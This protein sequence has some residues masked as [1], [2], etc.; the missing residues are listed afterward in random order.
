MRPTDLPVA[1]KNSG[2]A[3]ED[4]VPV[5]LRSPP[6]RKAYLRVSQLL[7]RLAVGTLLLSADPRPFFEYLFKSGRAFADF[8][9]RAPRAEIIGSAFSPV[10]D[11]MVCRDEPGV[12][13]LA[14][15]LPTAPNPSKEYEEDFFYLSIL[16][17]L[18]LERKTSARTQQWLNEYEKLVAESKQEDYRLGVCRALMSGA[19]DKIDE[20]LLSAAEH[21]QQEARRRHDEERFEMDEGNLVTRVSIDVLAWIEVADRLGFAIR[22]ALPMAPEIARPSGSMP[23]PA[24][25]SWRTP[26]SFR[27]L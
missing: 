5:V 16:V 10:L 20:T 23:L 24:P 8:C 1:V 9:A 12:R 22:G 18:Y 13:T 11:A 17:A 25:D 15:H 4:L 26:E 2:I 7:R 3:L 19:Q 6:H 27:S 14:S 21:V